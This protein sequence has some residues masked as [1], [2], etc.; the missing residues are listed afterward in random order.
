MARMIVMPAGKSVKREPQLTVEARALAPMHL[1]IRVPWH[2][3]G[4]DGAV[5][6]DPAANRSCL[7]LSRIAAQ[8]DEKEEQTL[9]TRVALVPSCATSS[10]AT[11][12]DEGHTLLPDSAPAP[13]PRA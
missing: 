4:W 7:I 2:D 11:G 8:K 1:S 10:S 12:A 6:N 9:L 3:R 13:A 5:C